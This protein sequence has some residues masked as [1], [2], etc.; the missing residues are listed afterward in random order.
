MI[1][2]ASTKGPSEAV[3]AVMTLPPGL[4]GEPRST[5]RS[6]NF[7]F[8]ASKAAYIS[9]IWAG[10][11]WLRFPGTLRWMHRYLRVDMATPLVNRAGSG[12]GILKTREAV[13]F[14]HPPATFLAASPGGT[15]F[16]PWRR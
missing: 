14:G 2:L 6:L 11:G 1:S 7:S 3:V 16:R 8:Q 13:R 9:C 15:G 5:M 4:R 12:P 10:E